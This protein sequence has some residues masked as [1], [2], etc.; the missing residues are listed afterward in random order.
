MT[1]RTH[2]QTITVL[3]ALVLGTAGTVR[4]QNGTVQY[5]KENLERDY[6]DGYNISIVLKDV[7]DHYMLYLWGYY[8]GNWGVVDSTEVKNGKACFRKNSSAKTKN[9]ISE[10]FPKGFYDIFGDGL[11]YV[12]YE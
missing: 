4:A 8:C 9:E 5:G 11:M 6:C 10:K 7:P 12:T 3:L 1:K 2:I